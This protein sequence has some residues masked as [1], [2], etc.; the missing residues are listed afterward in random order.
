[1][2]IVFMGT[3]SFA[4]SILEYLIPRHEV[5]AV[6]T[7]PDAVRGRGNGL[8]MSPV[9]EVALGAGIPIIE[10]TS[11]KDSALVDE[12]RAL[13]PDCI[14]V[15]AFGV[16]LPKTV[17]DIPFLGCLNVHASLLPRWRGAAPIARAIL[18]GD[19][20]A[21]VC[22]M[23]MEEGLDTGDYCVCRALDIGEMTVSELEAELAD[24]G[25]TALLTALEHIQ[26]DHAEWVRQNP[27]EVT[28]AYKIEK[29]ELNVSPDLDAFTIQRCVQA[30]EMHHPAKA[31]I[32]GKV[33]TLEKTH[34]IDVA[35]CER[36]S[37]LADITLD[38]GHVAFLSKRLL[39]G[40]A[41]GIVE[42]LNLKPDGKKSMDA[43]AFAAGIQNIK[44]VGSTWSAV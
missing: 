5:V 10:T 37:K 24:L 36:D 20:Q 38:P 2:R 43:Q 15:A 39:L 3:P 8:I 31:C 30:S 42:V 34:R 41:D 35:Q 22:I 33:V 23:K 12:L 19:E 40:C 14:C 13:K 16:L 27:D 28:Y 21:G 9:K 29:G 25:A 32:A 4:A 26:E 11:F 7:R 44:Q 17:L 1:M 18:A 6:Y